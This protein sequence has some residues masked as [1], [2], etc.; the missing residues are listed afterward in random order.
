MAQDTAHT[1]QHTERHA[2][3]QEPRGAGHRTRKTTHG[4]GTPDNRSQGAQDAAHAKQHTEQA[5]R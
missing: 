5:H 2:G 4:V 3:E 1:T